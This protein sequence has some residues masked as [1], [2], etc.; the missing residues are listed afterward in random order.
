MGN[1]A[2][3]LDKGCTNLVTLELPHC[4]FGDAGLIYFLRSLHKSSLPNLQ[5]LNLT[6]NLLCKV[7]FNY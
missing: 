6:N 5:N 3:S 1:I 4:R 2:K 7:D